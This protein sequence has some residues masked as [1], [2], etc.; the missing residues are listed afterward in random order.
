MSSLNRRVNIT[1]DG[2][3]G[4]N[5]HAFT[6]DLAAHLAE[7][8]LSN[9][10]DIQ[11]LT[12]D[13]VPPVPIPVNANQVTKKLFEMKM[14]RYF[15]YVL[16]SDENSLQTMTLKGIAIV[17]EHLGN[18]LQLQHA[19]L[20]NV[21]NT[22]GQ[23]LQPQ[24]YLDKWTR[25]WEL[26]TITL[27]PN[28]D[29]EIQ[30]ILTQMDTITDEY[31]IRFVIAFLADYQTRLKNHFRRDAQGNV[32][33]DANGQR[34]NYARDDSTLKRILLGTIGKRPE[35]ER[36]KFV[37]ETCEMNP[38]TSYSTIVTFINNII[39]SSNT[40]EDEVDPLGKDYDY[41][42]FKQKYL[43]GRTRAVFSAVTTKNIIN[44]NSATY[45]QQ[46][47]EATQP[48]PLNTN[49]N[50]FRRGFNN[51]NTS[52]NHQHL[53]GGSLKR[54]NDNRSN[55]TPSNYNN[56][57]KF[58]NFNANHSSNINHTRSSLPFNG[59]CAN[60][61]QPGHKAIDCQS[62]YCHHC[63]KDFGTAQKRKDHALEV[64]AQRRHDRK[65]AK[66]NNN[67]KRATTIRG[68]SATL[69]NYDE[70]NYYFEA[71]ENDDNDD[72]NYYEQYD[73]DQWEESGQYNNEIYDN[74]EEDEDEY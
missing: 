58:S 22:T 34:L 61:R 50:Q 40:T 62:S 70:S 65:R 71:N 23:N 68:K 9:L 38:S 19:D 69:K 73:S 67:N 44:N 33:L 46:Q 30:N 14:E 10:M 7:K 8:K 17:R 60:C 21:M 43:E 27:R 51:N 39:K 57:R 59:P 3:L 45:Q 55:M 49:N 72:D 2:R 35:M 18:N 52:N 53:P 20:L 74:N 5:Y 15:T 26:V 12:N 29:A 41:A 37:K 42:K 16:T 28:D 11:R 63:K 24:D 36:F 47:P 54:Y 66:H 13:M 4:E 31:G 25:V 32:L 56:K 6:E 64:H 1:F 48:A